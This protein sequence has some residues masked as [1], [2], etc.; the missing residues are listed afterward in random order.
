MTRRER[1][2]A[3][4]VAVGLFAGV[5]LIGRGD[6]SSD[7]WSTSAEQTQAEIDT[8]SIKGDGVGYSVEFGTLSAGAF[9][10]ADGQ[11]GFVGQP[12]LG[13]VWNDDYTIE[14][15]PVP[16][17]R[18][19]RIGRGDLEGDGDVDLIDFAAFTECLYGPGV[20]PN[21]TPPLSTSECLRAFDSEGDSDVDLDDFAMFQ[22]EF[23][24]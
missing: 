8:D 20:T 4:S 23:T 24:E 16:I 19:L 15:G 3:T 2:L 21:P 11:V 7:E 10:S 14:V 6:P 13:T 18:W 12:F 9:V 17:L 1:W 5:V 22:E